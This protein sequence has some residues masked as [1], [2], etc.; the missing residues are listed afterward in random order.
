MYVARNCIYDSSNEDTV[1]RI[2]NGV[3]RKTELGNK[4]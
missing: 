3:Y 4:L 2:N 1:L